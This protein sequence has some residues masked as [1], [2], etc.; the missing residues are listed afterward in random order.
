MYEIFKNALKGDYELVD[1]LNKIA[2]YYVKGNLSK[3]EK[4]ELEEEARNNA[5]PENSYAPL[6]ER[7][8]DLITRVDILEN[9]VSQLEKTSTG[10]PTEEPTE[11]VEEYPEYVK[12]TGAHDAY[13]V[14]DKIAYNDK[15]YECIYD[16][17]VWNPDEYPAGWKEV[18]E[19][20]ESGE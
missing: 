17:C 8:N 5:N 12:P 3:E 1:M 2:E 15:K 19:Q 20:V 16:G 6:E 10:E 11:P 13:H 9:K 7:L 18:T 4:E 14:G